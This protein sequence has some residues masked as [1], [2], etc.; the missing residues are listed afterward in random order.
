ME[1]TI[2]SM[3]T[4]YENR[5]VLGLSLGQSRIKNGKEIVKMAV[6]NNA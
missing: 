6:P 1:N 4:P 3:G 2:Q 5:L